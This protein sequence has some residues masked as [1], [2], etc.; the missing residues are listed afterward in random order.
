MQANTVQYSHWWKIDKTNEET[1]RK[2]PVTA[3]AAVTANRSGGMTHSDDVI[4]LEYPPGSPIVSVVTD[5][6]LHLYR[7]RTKPFHAGGKVVGC[8]QR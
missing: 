2:S 1:D 7:H 6:A 3:F 5:S 4:G 8:F